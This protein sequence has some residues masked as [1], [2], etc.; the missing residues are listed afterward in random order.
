MKKDLVCQEYFGHIIKE[1]RDSKKALIKKNLLS[2]FSHRVAIPI[3]T[4][5]K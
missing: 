1:I 3:L 2:I 4:G 5:R